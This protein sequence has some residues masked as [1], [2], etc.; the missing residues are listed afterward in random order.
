MMTNSRLPQELSLSMLSIVVRSRSG[1]SRVGITIET[2]GLALIAYRTAK[3]PGRDMRILASSPRLATA[4]S[5][6]L[7]AEMYAYGFASELAAAEPG[8][9]RQ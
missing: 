8:T 3:R 1:W 4:S 9:L 2:S 6:A 5:S 7:Y